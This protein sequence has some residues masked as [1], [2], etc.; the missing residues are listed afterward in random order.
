[1]SQKAVTDA[2]SSSSGSTFLQPFSDFKANYISS[3]D[4]TVG[5]I[6]FKEAH[7][8]VAGDKICAIVDFG[9]TFSYATA[10]PVPSGLPTSTKY[11]AG[12]GYK[13]VISVV[14]A[15]TI[16]IG[17]FADAT[18]SNVDLSKFFI[19]KMGLIMSIDSVT[20]PKKMTITSKGCFN[21]AA[22][23]FSSMV[24]SALINRMEI[25]FSAQTVQQNAM[26]WSGGKAPTFV[27]NIGPIIYNYINGSLYIRGNKTMI[28]EIE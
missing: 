21:V 19:S 8:I 17:A 12:T 4:A 9:T 2:L 18:P 16:N 27:N 13:V 10:F 26:Y 6:T 24:L 28:I 11:V 20:S 5:T 1:M 3:Y 7:D 25:N 14:D 23:F 22:P 15:N